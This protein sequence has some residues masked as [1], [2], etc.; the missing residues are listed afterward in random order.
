MAIIY[1]SGSSAEAPVT[2]AVSDATL[3]VFQQEVTNLLA[4]GWKIEGSTMYDGSLYVALLVQKKW[5]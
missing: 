3:A 1:A 4:S 2:A 5:N